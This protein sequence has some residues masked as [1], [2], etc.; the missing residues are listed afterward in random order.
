MPKKKP[1]TLHD[2]AAA[3]GV[4]LTTASQA[5]NNKGRV[6]EDTRERIRK[7]A[8]AMGYVANP[9][10]RALKTGQ[11]MILLTEIPGA[12]SDSGIYSGFIGEVLIGAADAAMAAGY[13]MMI[14]GPE[15]GRS[16]HLMCD[17]A[18]LVDAYPDDPLFELV[19]TVV[20][21]GRMIDGGGDWP[22]VDNDYRT[23]VRTTLNHLD[24]QGFQRPVLLV[25]FGPFSY[26]VDSVGAYEEWM[27]DLGR[28]GVIEAVGPLPDFS[29]GR[30]VVAELLD[31]AD[32]PDALFTSSEPLALAALEVI[33]A[34]GLSVPGDIGLVNL[35]DSERLRSA[36][37]PITGVDLRPREVGHRAVELLVQQL[38]GQGS[39]AKSA[40]VGATLV[41]RAST[42]RTA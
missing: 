32:P 6:N 27:Q 3:V 8:T 29:Q 21:V 28:K 11:A 15:V 20:T 7:T 9:R 10:A 36:S 37:V 42:L 4:S 39:S 41:P 14:G 31:R 25:P 16:P 5:L 26:S 12:R 30:A 38:S 40:L 24:A 34:R 33:E 18:V 23:A 35:Y 17:G 13:L 2:V 19:P 1:V 22:W